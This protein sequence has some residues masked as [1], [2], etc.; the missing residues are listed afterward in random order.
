MIHAQAPWLYPERQTRSFF[1]PVRRPSFLENEEA[2]LANESGEMSAMRA[3][4][5]DLISQN[6]ELTRRLQLLETTMQTKDIT[7]EH[8][9]SF[10]TPNGST[11]HEEPKE[12]ERPPKFGKEAERPPK[13]GQEAGRPP[14]PTK[15]AERPPEGY[16]SQSQDPQ[17]G[18][19]GFAEK[20]LECMIVMME[21]MKEMQKKIQDEKAE[22]GMVKGVEIVR[23]GPV[24]LPSLP[25]WNATQSPLQLSDR[26]LLIEPIVA[27]LSASADVWWKTVAQESEVWYQAHMLLSPLER[28]QHGHEVPLA[29]NQTRWQRLERRVSTMMLQA[30][31]DQIKEE[32]VSSRRMSVF[33]IVTHLYVADCPGGISEKQNLLKSLE[34]PPEISTLGESP[35]ALRKWLRW[36]QRATEIGATTPG[37]T[38]LVRGLV[39][40]T[41]R[42]L[43]SNRELQFRVSLARHALGIDTV[44]TLDSMTKSLGLSSSKSPH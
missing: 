4:M 8:E 33:A 42:V 7:P 27:D 10:S 22:G 12:A 9:V 38:L 28:L 39:R 37:P 35:A 14:K 21:T 44:P 2:R 11:A 30:V 43:E 6:E 5:R 31:P 17:S 24:E 19:P 34:D 26:L 23:T 3:H 16:G 32:L 20:S 41:K 18:T 1:P 13:F 29:L 40:M 36:R 15:E 25:L